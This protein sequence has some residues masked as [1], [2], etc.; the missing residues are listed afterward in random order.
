MEINNLSEIKVEIDRLKEYVNSELCKKCEEL[1]KRLIECERLVQ[2][3]SY[4]E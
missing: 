2:E 1:N 4:H 3:Y